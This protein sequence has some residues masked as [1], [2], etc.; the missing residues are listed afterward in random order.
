MLRMSAAFCLV[1]SALF[2]VWLVVAAGYV[3]LL[4]CVFGCGWGCLCGFVRL[5]YSG[6]AACAVLLGV[7]SFHFF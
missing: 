3:I 1:L 6:V 2:A 4:A 5:V 7:C